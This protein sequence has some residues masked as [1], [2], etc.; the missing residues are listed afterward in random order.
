MAQ[1]KWHRPA[2]GKLGLIALI[3][4]ALAAVWRFTPLASFVTP[5]RMMG[6]ARSL[7]G[8]KWAPFAL[9]AAY[10]PAAFLMFPRPLL[11]LLGVVALGLWMGFVCTVIG[12]LAAGIAT[13]YIGRLLPDRMVRRLAGSKFERV[14][15]V[16][17]EHGVLAIFAANMLPT[18]PFVVQGIMAGAIRIKLWHYALGTFLSL[19]PGLAAAMVF[20]HQIVTAFDDPSKVSY[21]LIGGTLVGLIAASVLAGRWFVRQA[22]S[23]AYPPATR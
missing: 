5:H 13:Y 6:F 14:T 16:L 12:V 17:R 21:L 11:T 2:W 7:G 22:K 3:F 15:P 10:V 1:R 18:P 23:T 20:G 8:T 9:V 4:I 19:L